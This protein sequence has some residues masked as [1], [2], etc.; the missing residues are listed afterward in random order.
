MPRSASQVPVHRQAEADSCHG[1]I[2]R[3]LLVSSFTPVSGFHCPEQ[4]IIPL[5]CETVV[6]QASRGQIDIRQGFALRIP[7]HS[8]R[9]YRDRTAVHRED[10]DESTDQV[11]G[12]LLRYSEL[13]VRKL[14]VTQYGTKR[15]S[16]TDHVPLLVISSVSYSSL[17]VTP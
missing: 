8:T 4:K 10:S 1:G 17:L 11:P 13:L 6:S 9:L 14:C 16:L 12:N 5:A 2:A 15:L 3:Q 7:D